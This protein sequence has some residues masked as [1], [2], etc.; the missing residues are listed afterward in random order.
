MKSPDDFDVFIMRRTEGME[1]NCETVA[2]FIERGDFSSDAFDEFERHIYESEF[3]YYKQGFKDCLKFL[4]G[5][6]LSNV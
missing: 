5:G 3:A 4:G 6:N 2:D 1:N